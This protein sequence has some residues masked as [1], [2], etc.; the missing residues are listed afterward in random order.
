MQKRHVVSFFNLPMRNPIWK[1]AILGLVID[2]FGLMNALW[3]PYCIG[4]GVWMSLYLAGINA[5]NHLDIFSSDSS[6]VSSE[7]S[8][9]S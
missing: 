1:I 3:L 6:S 7:P 8:D 9:E 5:E 4:C 2:R